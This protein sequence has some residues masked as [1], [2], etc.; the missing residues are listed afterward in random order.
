MRQ[1]M[2][3]SC[4]TCGKAEAHGVSVW[5]D[6][7]SQYVSQVFQD[8]LAFLGITRA[9]AFVQTPEDNGGAA[10]FIRTP[11]GN[12]LWGTTWD[13]GEA[14]RIARYGSFSSALTRPS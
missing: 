3:V 8:K 11:K 6:N 1:G 10:R 13:T 4:G 9:P 2:R 14:Q 7:G 12:R 5:H